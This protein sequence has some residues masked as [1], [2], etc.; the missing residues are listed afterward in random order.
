[1]PPRNNNIWS[2]LLWSPVI[3][4]QVSINRA[5]TLCVSR[6]VRCSCR[7]TVRT[8]CMCTQNA[9]CCVDEPTL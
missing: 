6:E 2:Y 3:V 5:R 7:L 8:V 9:A 1:M 4:Y